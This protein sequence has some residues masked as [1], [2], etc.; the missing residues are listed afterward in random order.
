MK[1]K[2]VY[3]NVKAV[4]MEIPADYL[5]VTFWDQEL[6]VSDKF[7]PQKAA[8]DLEDS[9]YYIQRQLVLE[10]RIPP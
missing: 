5:R 4:S 6:F 9:A 1:L 2:L 10:E 3:D 8:R 7:R